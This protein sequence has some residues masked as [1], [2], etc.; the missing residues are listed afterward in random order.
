M[1][2]LFSVVGLSVY[3]IPIRS[4]PVRDHSR[5]PPERDDVCLVTG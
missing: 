3:D 1:H 4:D 5:V 2:T